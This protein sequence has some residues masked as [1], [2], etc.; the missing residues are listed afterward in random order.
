LQ[1]YKL[2]WVSCNIDDS[3]LLKIIECAGQMANR[4]PNVRSLA[5]K[6][7][8]SLMMKVANRIG[9][10]DFDFVPPTF[11]LPNKSEASRLDEYMA[12]H[13]NATFIAKPQVGS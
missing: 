9:G 2:K 6:D 4:Y 5:H 7:Q 1:D 12:K 8:F 3:E 11:T 13:R 10:D